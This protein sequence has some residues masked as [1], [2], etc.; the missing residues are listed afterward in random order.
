MQDI[1]KEYYQIK[2]NLVIYHKFVNF[3]EDHNRYRAEIFSVH[4]YF[5]KLSNDILH[6][7]V[8]QNFV[9]STCLSKVLT[10]NFLEDGNR[11]EVEIFRVYLTFNELSNNVS[12]FVVAQNFVISTCLSQR[13]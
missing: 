13:C 6:F 3:L 10:I 4:L 5:N 2:R 12:H 8:A 9:I 11:Y 1:M 7:V